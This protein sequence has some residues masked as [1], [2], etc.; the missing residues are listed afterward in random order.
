MTESITLVFGSV[1]KTVTMLPV[2]TAVQIEDAFAVQYKWQAEVTDP[3]DPSST[4]P[5]PETKSDLVFRMV[6]EFI[7]VTTRAA[8]KTTARDTAAGTVDEEF[9]AIEDGSV[10]TSP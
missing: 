1:S 7:S 8:S 9:D 3:D 10:V 6:R 4:I 2:G 5:N